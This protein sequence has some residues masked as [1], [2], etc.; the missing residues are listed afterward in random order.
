VVG[1]LEVGTDVVGAGAEVVLVLGGADVAVVV[2]DVDVAVDVATFVDVVVVVPHES[3]KKETIIKKLM[4]AQNNLLFTRCPSSIIF[5]PGTLEILQL[6]ISSAKLER[7]IKSNTGKLLL[8]KCSLPLSI[9]Y[10]LDINSTLY[11]NY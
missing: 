8:H 2:L 4:V 11:S 3:N 7:F 5:I 1:G 6:V 9:Q 10:L